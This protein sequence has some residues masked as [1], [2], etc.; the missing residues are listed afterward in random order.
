ME[1]T[2]LRFLLLA[3]ELQYENWKYDEEN[4]LMNC[5]AILIDEEGCHYD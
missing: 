2:E 5:S 1:E 4:D 3:I